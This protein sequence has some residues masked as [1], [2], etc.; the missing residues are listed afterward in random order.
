MSYSK[1]HSR[2]NPLSPGRMYGLTSS[3]NT[4]E[5]T[6]NGQQ[7]TST[8]EVKTSEPTTTVTKEKVE[9]GTN[10]NTNTLAPKEIKKVTVQRGGPKTKLSDDDYIQSLIDS[11]HTKESI[12][13]NPGLANL[14]YIDRFPDAESDTTTSTEFVPDPIEMERI[15]PQPITFPTIEP[16]IRRIETGG[17][18]EFEEE[19]EEVKIKKERRGINLPEINFNLPTFQKKPKK[20]K[21]VYG[22]GKN[23]MQKTRKKNKNTQGRRKKKNKR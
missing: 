22:V 17:G 13:E 19:E 1:D 7:T 3:A 18:E 23:G 20:T 15:E 10:V 21:S 14:S 6:P 16:T 5:F 11:G 4:N 9:G 8:E 12:R 2:R